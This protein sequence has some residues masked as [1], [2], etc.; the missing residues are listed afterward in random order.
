MSWGLW[1]GTLGTTASA[2]VAAALA[3]LLAVLNT[4]TT[5][6]AQILSVPGVYI[7]NILAR[8]YNST[9]LS[10]KFRKKKKKVEKKKLL[11]FTICHSYVIYFGSISITL[12]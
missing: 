5:P 6:R 3:A 8:E 1:A 9:V 12:S 2:L 7:M 4:A 10:F 11:H